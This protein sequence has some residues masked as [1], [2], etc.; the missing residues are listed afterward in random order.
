EHGARPPA[1]PKAAATAG[2][3]RQSLPA[4]AT[5]PIGPE[6]RPPRPLAPSSAGQDEGADPPFPPGADTFAARRGVLIHRLL[7]RLP[8]VPP[9]LRREL[10]GDWLARQAEDVAEAER[11]AML[12]SALAV[13]E[14][15]G[16]A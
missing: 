14:E 10:A 12:E 11:A 3:A 5:T 7:E 16:W 13:L 15:P 9:L 8:E 4:W 6:P 2:D 1:I